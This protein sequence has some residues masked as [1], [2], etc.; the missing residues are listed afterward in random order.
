MNLDFIKMIKFPD[1]DD[2]LV[3]IDVINQI[4]LHSTFFFLLQNKGS[5]GNPS[6]VYE[7]RSI[8]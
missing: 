3:M 4:N 1:P 2:F 8:G 7:V 5:S 6:A